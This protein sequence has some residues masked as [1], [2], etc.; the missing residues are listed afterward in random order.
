MDAHPANQ[1][2]ALRALVALDKFKG[3]LTAAEAVAAVASGLRRVRP[4]W[5]IDALPLADGG[6]GTTDVLASALGGEWRQAEVRD[7]LGRRIQAPW[8]WFPHAPDGPWALI[9][10]SAAAGLRHLAAAERDPTRATT[11]GVGQLVFTAL[12]TGARRLV[13][14]LG[15]SATNDG[16]SGF[17]RALGHRFLDADDREITDLPLGLAR[18][19]RIDSSTTLPLPSVEALCDVTNPLLGPSGATAVFGPQKGVTPEL[20]PSLE[21]ALARLADVAADHSARDIRHHPGAGAAGG[22]GF[23]LL[24]FADARLVGGFDWIAQKLDLDRRLATADFVIT[25]EG[26]IDAQ[27]VVGKVPGEVLARGRRLGKPCHAFAGRIDY[28]PGF[29]SARALMDQN[30]ARAFAAPT[31][32]LE[33]LAATWARDHDPLAA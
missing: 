30:P 14:G 2:R 16:G 22:L 15:G 11:D 10:M 26:C 3:T 25:G 19:A 33:D 1:P 18:L 7:A 12:A 23:G 29:A 8:L 21:A 32:A 4:D 24:A 27:S 9:E 31:A 5:T 13:V 20:A 17:A 6:D 28:D